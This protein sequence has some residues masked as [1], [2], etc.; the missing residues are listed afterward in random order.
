MDNSYGRSRES[1][2]DLEELLSDIMHS[3]PNSK[4]ENGRYAIPAR[5]LADILKSLESRGLLTLTPEDEERTQS[6]IA[7]L[8]SADPDAKIDDTSL[9]TLVAQL[10]RPSADL[11][12]NEDDDEPDR[13]RLRSLSTSSSS[14][15]GSNGT[16]RYPSRPPSRSDHPPP[17]PSQPKTPLDKRPRSTPLSSNPPSAFQRRPAPVRRKSSA[18]PGRGY[19]SGG[20]GGD[21]D[22]PSSVERG[23]R[24]RAG[25]Q[26]ATTPSSSSTVFPMS[27]EVMSPSKDRFLVEGGSSSPEDSTTRLPRMDYD[28]EN[29]MSRIPMPFGDSDSSDDELDGTGAS[30][31]T[32]LI[33]DPEHGARSATSSTASLLPGERLEALSRANADLAKRLLEAEDSYSRKI[34]DHESDLAELEQKLDEARSDLARSKR[35][36]KELRNKERNNMSQINSLEAEV[37]RLTKDLALTKE[38]YHT[39]QKQY[40]EQTS[41]SERYRGDLRNRE[42]TIRTLREQSALQDLEI[43]KM[44]EREKEWEDRVAKLEREVEKAQEGYSELVQQKT[45]NV[46]LKETIDRLK[47]E[48]DDMRGAMNSG[49]GTFGIPGS[50]ASSRANTISKS[51]GAELQSQLEKEERERAEKDGGDDTEG[52]DT[53]VEEVVDDNDEEGNFITTIIKRTRRKVTSKAQTELPTPKREYSGGKTIERRFEE[54]EEDKEYADC[55]IQYDPKAFFDPESDD[56]FL[57]SAS[58]Q[59]DPEPVPVEREMAEMD[60][61]TEEMEEEDESSS[62]STT[63]TPTVPTDEPPAYPGPS[64]S[65]SEKEREQER[66]EQAELAVLR[67]WHRSQQGRDALDIREILK[68]GSRGDFSVPK[69]IMEDW[70]RIQRVAGVDCDVVERLLI[71]AA[72]EGINDQDNQEPSSKDESE[73]RL[74]LRR[75]S[76]HLPN[77]PTKLSSYIHPMVVYGSLSV[78]VGVVLAPHMANQMIEYGGAT[79][80]DRRA[81]ASFNALGAGGEGFPGFGAGR[82]GGGAEGALWRVLEAVIGGGARYARGMPT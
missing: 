73:S 59:T 39:L 44:T 67:K 60:I 7:T 71:A 56:G 22:G 76:S 5:Y 81:W 43:G 30:T 13:G 28:F 34:L 82:Y 32:H 11:L 75:L 54:Y 42:D 50:G 38:S 64:T 2:A 74:S 37:A 16:S 31:Y 33:F 23:P 52:E 65:Q 57:R 70:A 51:L 3:H 18:S 10:S 46:L 78:I 17:T 41:L 8:E 61:Q 35:E 1:I 25:S 15:S 79:A 58:L 6:V 45:E 9:F 4:F 24:S 62:S 19:S 29:S 66:E 49:L 47:F 27:P 68:H 80:Y 14:S 21:S 20:A 12:S 69:G 77:L 40:A 53:V 63:A 48:I 26:S 55:A 72:A 36:E